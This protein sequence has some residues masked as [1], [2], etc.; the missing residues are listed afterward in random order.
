MTHS[1]EPVNLIFL[2]KYHSNCFCVQVMWRNF[3]PIPSYIFT[4]NFGGT[5]KL[6]KH[7]H[8]AAR[9]NEIL[10]KTR[11]SISIFLAAMLFST[12]TVNSYSSSQNT[13][14]LIYKIK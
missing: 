9:H 4:I 14:R 1:I 2:S 13:L 7:V 3:L 11:T 8:L 5:S 10:L 12:Y 6:G